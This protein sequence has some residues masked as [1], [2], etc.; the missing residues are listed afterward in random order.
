MKRQMTD[1]KKNAHGSSGVNQRAPGSTAKES[2]VWEVSG[3]SGTLR[4]ANNHF[5][6]NQRGRGPHQYVKG[7]V[8]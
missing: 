7:A 5:G 8:D 6:P 2:L 1:S 4:E 3:V